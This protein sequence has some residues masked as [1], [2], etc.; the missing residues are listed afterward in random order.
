MTVEPV[1]LHRVAEERSRA[2]HALIADR[3]AAE[4]ALLDRARARV[5]AWR[6]SGTVARPYVERWAAILAGPID[7]IAE[8]LR[9]PGEEARELRQASPFAGA[10]DPRTRWE[11]WRRVRAEL[12]R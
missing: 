1:S 8:L 12:G 3:L 10:V 5:E 9:D 4:P 6:V 7:A 11:V 2:L